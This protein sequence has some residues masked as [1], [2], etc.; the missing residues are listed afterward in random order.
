[1]RR[2][3]AHREEFDDALLD[4]LQAEVVLV[5]HVPRFGDV[6]RPLRGLGPRQLDQPVQIGADHARLGRGLGHALVA[7]QFLARQLLDLVGHLRLVDRLRQVGDLLRLS[8]ALAELALD[9]RHLL[10]QDRFALA[11]VEGRLGALADLL[12]QAHHLDAPGEEGRDLVDARAQVDRLE[13]FL[14]VVAAD[15]E[16]GGDQ[17]GERA[18]PARRLDGGD[19]LLRHLR[20][21][22][23]RLHRLLLQMQQPRLD[24]GALLVG[25]V[26]RHDA[27]GEERALAHELG[28]AKALQPLHD[29]VMTAVGHVHVAQ[30]VR[31]RAGSMHVDRARLRG[32]GLALHQDADR[33]LFAQ[34]LLGGEDRRL[35]SDRDREHGAGKEHGVAH[36]DDDQDFGGQ[37]RQRSAG[38]LCGRRPGSAFG[39]GALRAFG[40]GASCAFGL[41]PLCAFGRPRRLVRVEFGAGAARGI[42]WVVVH[43]ASFRSSSAGGSRDS[44]AR[45]RRV[46][47]RSARAAREP[48]ARSVPAEARAGG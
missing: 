6:D 33:P 3:L 4:L 11:L 27:R 2:E 41:G 42:A 47:R 14:L 38:L 24:F 35:A 12:R 18:G 44:P 19:Q 21:Q 37:R 36:R 23:Q 46:R 39:V 7:A 32:V 20:Q 28:D 13:Q 5:E 29:D 43:V 25:L 40:V 17:V 8:V 16:I 31:H 1:M 10:A 15:V 30:D 26:D 34:R 22:L 45:S 9:R 48:G